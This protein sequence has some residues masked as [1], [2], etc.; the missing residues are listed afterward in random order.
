[1][2]EAQ[3]AMVSEWM[4]NGNIIDFVKAN[5]GAN[6]FRLVRFHPTS[7]CHTFIDR[8]TILQ[9]EGVAKGLIYVHGRG[10]IHGDLKGVRL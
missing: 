1:M 2:T 4:V 6:R 9:L 10:M 7:R 3:F 8:R 5:P